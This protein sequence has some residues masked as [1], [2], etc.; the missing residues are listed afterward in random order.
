[1]SANTLET[2][3]LDTILAEIT[4]ASIGTS[5]SNVTSLGVSH[6]NLIT[7]LGTSSGALENGRADK[8][9]VFGVSIGNFDVTTGQ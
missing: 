5:F 7:D 1:M 3:K 2:H 4:L 6:R 8:L 9:L